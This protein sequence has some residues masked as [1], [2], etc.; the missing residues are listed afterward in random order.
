MSKFE[1]IIFDMDGTLIDS[2]PAILAAVS[3]ATSK[4][5][6]LEPSMESLRERYNGQTVDYLLDDL[7]QFLGVDL[8]GGFVPVLTEF[9]T[10]AVE[11]EI[12]A[13]PGAAELLESLSDVPKCVA[14]NATKLGIKQCLTTTALLSNFGESVFSAEEVEN[15]KPAPDVFL[16]AAKSMGANPGNCV[17]IED[18]VLG[19]QAG[20]TAGMTVIGFGGNDNPHA[21][22][23]HDLGVQVIADIRDL[24][25]IVRN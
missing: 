12:C 3:K 20:L 8:P 9:Y 25:H 23:L 21:D 19:V 13:T 11:T 4:T 15:P 24:E 17:V 14:S 10:T 1:L 2:E 6:N 22:E 7:P 18:S 16:H 5:M